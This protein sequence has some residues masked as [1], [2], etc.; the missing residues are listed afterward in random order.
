MRNVEIKARLGDP[1]RVERELASLGARDAGM[2]TQHDVFFHGASGRLKLRFSSR[3]GATL[4]HYER[5]D[6]AA[7][8]ASEYEVATVAD[9]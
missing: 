7:L 1:A 3:S 2:E 4:I 6:A 8:R 9:A 5:P